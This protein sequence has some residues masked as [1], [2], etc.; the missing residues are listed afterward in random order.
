MVL[1]NASSMFRCGDDLQSLITHTHVKQAHKNTSSFKYQEPVPNFQEPWIWYDTC[2][3]ILLIS[4]KLFNPSELHWAVHKLHLSART[5]MSHH[6]LRST[7]TKHVRGDTSVYILDAWKFG[8][9]STQ[10]NA[11]PAVQIFHVREEAPPIC[12]SIYFNTV[13]IWRKA[14]CYIC[15]AATITPQIQL[16]LTVAMSHAHEK[17]T[18]ELTFAFYIEGKWMMSTNYSNIYFS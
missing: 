1:T 16:M 18:N 15:V 8:L 9:A 2:I 3:S 12:H 6:L 11:T 10:Q 5:Q 14:L 17:N 13:W 7:S 4:S